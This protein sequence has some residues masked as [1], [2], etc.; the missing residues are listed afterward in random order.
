MIAVLNGSRV[1]IVNNVLIAVDIVL[2]IMNGVKMKRKKCPS[3]FA[4]DLDVMLDIN[5]I[6]L[7]E[8]GGFQLPPLIYD[9]YHDTLT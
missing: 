7:V 4:S 8:C 1:E 6:T 5:S 2:L 9:M 3:G